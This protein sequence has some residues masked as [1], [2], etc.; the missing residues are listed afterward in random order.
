VENREGSAWDAIELRHLRAFVALSEE[1]NFTRAARRLSLTQPAFSRTIA[2][3]ERVLGAE[4]VRRNRRVVV[5]TPRGEQVAL[6][7]RRTLDVVREVVEAAR[8]R[9]TVLRVGF[10]WGSSAEYTG[11]TVRAFE[12][13]NP[14]V[15]VELRRY[16][17][18]LAGVADGRT[19][20][21]FLPG[22]P[23]DERV[24]FV[25]LGEEVRVAALPS[26]HRLARRERLRLADLEN[27]SIVVNVIS[28]TTTMD[29]WEPGHRPLSVVR[30]RNVDEWM[31][32]IA[33]R[34]GVGLTPASTGRLYSH[35]QIR[36]VPIADA[37]S[38]PIVLAW[39]VAAPHPLVHDFA[40]AALSATS[41]RR[42]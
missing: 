42:G 9:T 38:V 27:D 25:V 26:D 15:R 16:D 12:D 10:T 6:H 39:P 34:R 35:P 14:D 31:E 41:A 37:P 17:D 22:L 24:R 11:P 32:A 13:G 23:D 7:A 21:G 36:Y 28:G 1:R 40:E 29:L 18:T 20:V 19:H 2:Q 33:A 4:L 30:V 3:L 5:V 8:A